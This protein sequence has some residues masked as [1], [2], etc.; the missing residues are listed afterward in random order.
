MSVDGHS[1][2]EWPR[3][4]RA[5]VMSLR[6]CAFSTFSVCSHRRAASLA[7]PCVRRGATSAGASAT[8][9]AGIQ[10]RV[11]RRERT[12][13][14]RRPLSTSSKDADVTDHAT[15]ELV[16]AAATAPPADI[17]SWR[18]PYSAGTLSADELEQFWEEGYVIKHGL[19][20]EF[21][22][23]PVRAAIDGLVGEVADELK[24]AGLIDDDAAQLGFYER[25]SRLEEQFPGAAVLLHKR[26]VLPKAFQ[27]LW[28]APVLLSA[29]QQLVG[30]D[31]DGH[32]VWNLRS[33][34]PDNEEA[35]VPWH[36]DAVSCHREGEVEG[37]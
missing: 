36:Q 32:P 33:K 9:A 10:P 14:A 3:A 15:E 5:T 6:H 21:E 12:L 22:L 37:G 28:S 34:V 8:W 26:G 7:P 18:K 35:T 2:G 16:R 29:A 1:R 27:D 20:S 30:P 4:S 25:L 19:F 17:S 23:E 13:P 24:A 31:I 11:L